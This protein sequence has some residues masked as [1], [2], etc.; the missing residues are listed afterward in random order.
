M[1]VNSLMKRFVLGI[2]SSLLLVIVALSAN[3]AQAQDMKIAVLDVQTAMFNT[4]RA[5]AIDAQIQEETAEDQERVRDLA[6]QAQELQQQLRQDEA[7]LSDDEKQRIA[8]QIEE[9]GVQYEYLVQKLQEVIQTR[10][11]Q[12]QQSYAPSLIQAIS[13]VVEEEDYDL[14]LRAETAL[15][16][17]SEYDITAKVTAKLNEQLADE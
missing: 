11:Q 1:N 15:H 17:R 2:T 9:I 3:A 10:Q 12:F 8:G 4:E 14:V 16:F 5:Q 7:T 6:S 13:D